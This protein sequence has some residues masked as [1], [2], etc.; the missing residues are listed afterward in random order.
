M[1][2]RGGLAL[3]MVC[4]LAAPAPAEESPDADAKATPP[5]IHRVLTGGYWEHDKLDGH[6]RVVIVAGGH[7]HVSHRL[8]IQWIA[9]DPD[10]Q[11]HKIAWTVP[12]K[13]IGDLS[14]V[15]TDLK[16]EFKPNSPARFIVTLEG[17]DN[18]KRRL[19]VTA[20]PNGRYTAR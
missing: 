15:I 9:I 5:G 13:E 12:V 8:F 1:L 4:A 17:R 11:D 16:P 18:K 7:E 3:A 19:V 2:R 6:Y 20:T 14:G 10:K